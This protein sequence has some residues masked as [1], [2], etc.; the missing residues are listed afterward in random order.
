MSTYCIGTITIKDHTAWA[1]Y[2][3][4]VG[5]TITAHGGRVLFR[6]VSP[7][8][9]GGAAPSA[10]SGTADNDAVVVLVFESAD[11][12]RRWHDSAAYQALI[13]LRDRGADVVLTMYEGE[14]TPG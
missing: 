12:A 3:A 1:E 10:F 8:S 13:P 6:G 5:A 4:A 2:R 11:A 14:P 9:F 7:A